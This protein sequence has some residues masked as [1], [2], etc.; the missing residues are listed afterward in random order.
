VVKVAHLKRLVA[1]E[2]WPIPKKKYTWTFAPSPG[3]HK[4]EECIPLAII[5][6]DILGLAQT[7]KEAKR[8]IRAREILVDGKARTD[9]RYPVGLLDVV[10]IPKINK[11]Y[12]VVPY[13]NGLR[14]IEIDEN[15]AKKKILKIV[16]KRS[17]KGNRFQL[18]MNDGK[19]LIV[20]EN[21]YK[22]NASLL[23]ELPSLKI[24]DY[25]EMDV[26]NLVLITSGQNSGKVAR[27][28]EI[29]EGK[30]N[31]KPKLT[32]EIEGEKIEALKEHA[33]VIGKEEPLIKVS[34]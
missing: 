6:R 4:K 10:S 25:I 28:V 33:I 2:F 24:L 31:V 1:P 27:I 18:N 20:N 11:H 34:E 9:H 26:G 22:T 23:V 13:K 7:G 29:K 32:C 15:D 14:L 8:I 5:V 19:N 12:R 16:G 30:F 17:I 3:P 21:K